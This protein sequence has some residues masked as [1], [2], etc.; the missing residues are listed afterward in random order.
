M[1]FDK[2]REEV[3]PDR[4]SLW[5]TFGLTV[6]MIPGVAV[7]AVM[8]GTAVLP[9]TTLAALGSALALLVTLKKHVTHADLCLFAAALMGQNIILTLALSGHPWQI[10]SHIFYFTNVA[11][12][13][14]LRS[15][16]A[17][18]VAFLIVAV[19][20]A[21]L[22]LFYPALVFPA[23]SLV[24]SIARL[25]YH[26][27][28]W[29]LAIG[30][31]VRLLLL[32]DRTDAAR[33]AAQAESDAAAQE[34][35]EARLATEASRADAER[36]AQEAAQVVSRLGL[37]LRGLAER[38]LTQRM[39]HNVPD[40]FRDLANNYDQAIE[41]MSAALSDVAQE[42]QAFHREADTSAMTTQSMAEKL[43]SQ[44][45]QVSE[46]SNTIDMLSTSLDEAAEEIA[47]LKSRTEQASR[48]ADDGGAVVRQA[49]S[50]MAEVRA[51]SQEI[52]SIIQVIEDISFQT[53]LLALNAGVEA[54]RAGSAGSG[55]AVVAAEVRALAHRTSEAANE[56]KGLVSTS[57]AQV[58]EGAD[59]V[60]RAGSAL[61][62]IETA[63]REANVQ[64]GSITARVSEQTAQLREMSSSVRGIDQALQGYAAQTE[65]LS[66]M[67]S[68]ISQ[69]ATTLHS[70][71]D[72]FAL[73]HGGMSATPLARAS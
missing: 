28:V 18:V 43:E 66:A 12:L 40:A 54:A 65:E 30:F 61:E 72:Q 62:V 64:A 20:H 16:P 38:D 19:Q 2:L 3:L 24:D 51:S 33:A 26:A 39:G 67:A 17:L 23:A 1:G 6:G 73:G 58:G 9:L 29:V 36:G 70:N 4:L 35:Q 48:N 59:L 11:V 42:A 34:A 71:M 53:N 21:G 45:A 41:Q 56:V 8:A 50:T 49:V 47:A 7:A 31:L 15:I 13:A 27:V 55:F 22:A 25:A 44:A 14:A 57:V 37:A 10:D 69:S 5:L 32:Q 63:I 68:T 60:D 46:A 52:S